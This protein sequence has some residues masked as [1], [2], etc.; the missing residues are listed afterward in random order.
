MLKT[1]PYKI[2][3][4]SYFLRIPKHLVDLLSIGKDTEF[5]VTFEKDEG[6]ISL[7]YKAEKEKAC[8]EV[9]IHEA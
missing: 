4:N 6:S 1:H 9:L 5:L 2:G 3:S 8:K 7:I